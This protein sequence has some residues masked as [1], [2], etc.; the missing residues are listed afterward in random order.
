MDYKIIYCKN[1]HVT[2]LNSDKLVT[3]EITK[4][5]IKTKCDQCLDEIETDVKEIRE[6]MKNLRK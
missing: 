4:D 5:T 6:L 2:M 1:N 3:S